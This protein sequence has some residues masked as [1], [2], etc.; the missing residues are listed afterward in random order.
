MVAPITSLTHPSTSI[1][2]PPS[3]VRRSTRVINK[4]GY[5]NDFHCSLVYT[6]DTP[7]YLTFPHTLSKVLAYD[8]LSPSYRVFALSISLDFEPFEPQFFYQ[9]VKHEHWRVAMKEE[10]DSM[11]RTATWSV[12]PLLAGKQAIGCRWIFKNKFNANSTIARHKARLV[13]KGYNQQEGIDFIDTFSPVAK[14]VTIKMLL[15]FA[16]SHHWHLA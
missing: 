1:I 15:G 5:L 6:S 14:L 3:T 9:A 13:A 11:E 16:A 10:L 7:V 12:V 2:D 8:T 4:L